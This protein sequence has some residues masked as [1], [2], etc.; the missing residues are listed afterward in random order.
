VGSDTLGK[1]EFLKLMMAQM[2]NQDPTAPVDNQAFVAQLAQFSSLEQLT[3]V[4]TTLSSLLTAQAAG[5]Q[6]SVVGM[7][8]KDAIYS[9]SSVT[10]QAGTPA[11]LA[12]QLAA[13]ASQVTAAITDST[14]KVVRTMQL[15]A[16]L[17][18]SFSAQWD[19]TDDSGKA[20]AAGTYSVQFA[21]KATD[22]TSVAV[23]Q[24]ARSRILGVSYSN[25][26]AQLQLANGGQISLSDIIEVAAPA[27]A[28]SQKLVTSRPLVPTQ[29]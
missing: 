6:T 5:N 4:N 27:S 12:G 17:A 24:Q 26:V 9:G 1:D 15:G 13:N 28:S 29:R 19:G 2:A 11:T 21:A 8:G 22:G 10:L 20:A 23:Q 25:G 3:N 7:V 16:T 14:G 18:G